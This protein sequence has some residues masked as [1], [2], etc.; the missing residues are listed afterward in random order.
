MTGSIK[1]SQLPAA[2]T[3]LTGAEAVPLVQGGTTKQATVADVTTVIATGSTT[4]RSLAAR[5]ADVVNVKDF[6]AV[7]DGVVDDTAAFA[8]V[9]TA[10]KN[11]KKSVYVPCGTYLVD[12]I[13]YT[14]TSYSDQFSIYGDGRHQTIIRKRVTSSSALFTIGSVSATNFMANI[15]VEGITF[16]GL[17]TTTEAAVRSYNLV[18]S[19]FSNCGFINSSIGR[20][21]F[22]GIACF[23][24]DCFY[25]TNGTGLKM[26]N[27]AGAAGGDY[28]NLWA[29]TNAIIVDNTTVG[30]NIDGGWLIRFV[31]GEVEENGTTLGAAGQGGIIVGPNMGIEVVSTDT[32]V[33]GVSCEGTWFE[34]NKGVAD[35]SMASGK[36]RI[37]G[38]S[39]R[40]TAA[41]VTYDIL[42]NGGQYTLVD[43]DS[44]F[45][46][47]DN[48]KEMS[49]SVAGNLIT[50][51]NMGSVSYTAS[52]TT[53]V[54]D[55][56]I[57][58]GYR[59][60]KFPGLTKPY[61][62]RGS[63]SS[64]VNP[65][66]TFAE[67][68]KVGSVPKVYL[69]VVNNSASTID[70]P[71]T[72]D[73]TATSF[74]IRKKSFNGATIGTVNYSVEWLAVGEAP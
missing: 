2:T 64:G 24:T 66:I 17:N 35:F 16:D 51:S 1:I 55:G 69:S 40:S 71:E 11:T 19:R 41:Q 6:G 60:G 29:F 45:A 13:T 28:P 27:F 62:Q 25:S 9:I 12:S 21:V 48:V 63:D 4:A 58:Q 70:T 54:G 53:V 43:C 49:G 52:K 57:E 44:S 42:V 37:T 33:I 50:S 23:E 74:K 22:G 30:A 3:P 34:S 59:V 67:V 10:A 5:A 20:D 73:I 8:A 36:T 72:Y 7:G 56:F 47:T 26:Q 14:S 15:S 39:F 18:R 68:F 61:V 38:C 65:T 31:G 46:K 32:L